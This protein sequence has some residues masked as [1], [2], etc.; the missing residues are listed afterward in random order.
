LGDLRGERYGTNGHLFMGSVKKKNTRWRK[1]GGKI[2]YGK[3]NIGKNGS[4]IRRWGGGGYNWRQR[5]IKGKL[6]LQR[7]VRRGEGRYDYVDEKKN[8]GNKKKKTGRSILYTRQEGKGTNWGGENEMVM[9][10]T[11]RNTR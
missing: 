10:G 7:L 5:Q 4:G 9:G 8:R 6:D 11:L 1:R 2:L 3:K